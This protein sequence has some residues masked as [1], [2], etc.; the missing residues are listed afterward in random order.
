MTI[1]RL[2]RNLQQSSRTGYP[3]APLIV[4]LN[5]KFVF[6]LLPVGLVLLAVPL[7]VSGWQRRGGLQGFALAIL[8]VFLY[9]IAHAVATSLGREAI[10]NPVV[11]TWLPIT[12][13]FAVGVGM[14]RRAR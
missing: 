10:V 12:I 11:I 2:Y 9:Y 5:E 4:G 8:I 6:P 13:V 7:T 14:L 1:V 3:A